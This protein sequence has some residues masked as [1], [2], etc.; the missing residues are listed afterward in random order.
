MD[1]G[2][3]RH[4]EVARSKLLRQLSVRT[5][6][7][8]R[9]DTRCLRRVSINAFLVNTICVSIVRGSAFTRRGDAACFVL[10]ILRAGCTRY[11]GSN[12]RDLSGYWISWL[13]PST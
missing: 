6:P 4:E 1:V 12:P 5:R 8:G 7:P 10:V 13:L 9:R 11:L 2:E 3:R